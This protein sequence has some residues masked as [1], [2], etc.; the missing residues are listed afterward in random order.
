MSSTQKRLLTADNSRL[1]KIDIIAML[2]TDSAWSSLP[3]ST[4]QHLYTLL[5][6]RLE[7]ESER[8][9]DINPLEVERLKAYLKA[10]IENW[11]D[12]LKEGREVKKWRGEGMQVSYVWFL[13]WKDVVGRSVGMLGCWGQLLIFLMC[14][15]RL[16]RIMWMASLMSGRF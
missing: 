2:K 16:A 7:N 13:R 11:Q 14:A 4:R 1:G 12:D 8:D 15:S 6:P 5:P 9:P 3:L 10:E